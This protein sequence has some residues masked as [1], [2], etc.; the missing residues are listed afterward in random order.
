MSKENVISSSIDDSKAELLKLNCDGDS[1]QKRERNSITLSNCN[2]S[3]LNVDL[4]VFNSSPFS[5]IELSAIFVQ[6]PFTDAYILYISVMAKRL[7]AILGF[8][9][10]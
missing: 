5:D 9:F 8:R 1:T 6:N 10:K 4:L 3:Y 2:P 7:I